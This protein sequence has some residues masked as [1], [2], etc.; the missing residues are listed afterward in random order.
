L[1][2]ADVEGGLIILEMAAEDYHLSEIAQILESNDLKVLN[3]LTR[4][5]A[6]STQI[7][8]IIKTHTRDL[9]RALQTFAR[10]DYKVRVAEFEDVHDLNL[11]ERYEQLMR[12]LNV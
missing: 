9:S 4:P 1:I 11:N 7:E 8:V 10:Y 5:I 12:Y 3:L 2:S 6:M